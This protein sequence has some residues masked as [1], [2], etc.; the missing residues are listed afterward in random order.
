[1]A[2]IRRAEA[3]TGGTR[4]FAHATGGTVNDSIDGV[5][6]YTAEYCLGHGGGDD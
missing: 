4:Q 1:M 3:F 5:G 6:T 2:F